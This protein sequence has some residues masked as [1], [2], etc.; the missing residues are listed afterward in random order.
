[1]KLW[2]EPKFVEFLEKQAVQPYAGTPEE[3]SEF[4]KKDRAD[5]EILV[6]LANAPRSDF[7]APK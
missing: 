6:K 4:L 7:V 1:M 3:F 2:R 5:S